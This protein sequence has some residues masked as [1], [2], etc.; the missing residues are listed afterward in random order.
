MDLNQGCPFWDPEPWAPVTMETPVP[1]KLEMS[2]FDIWNGNS[3][4]GSNIS[5]SSFLGSS[6]SVA[7]GYFDQFQDSGAPA[8]ALGYSSQVYIPQASSYSMRPGMATTGDSSVGWQQTPHTNLMAFADAAAISN[9]SPFFLPLIQSGNN[10]GVA[11]TPNTLSPDKDFFLKLDHHNYG[12]ADNSTPNTNSLM[13]KTISMGGADA[14]P[15][16]CTPVC[17][18]K[19]KFVQDYSL[20][21]FIDLLDDSSNA[22]DKWD[23]TC[24]S[25]SPVPKQVE[26]GISEFVS[27]PPSLP[28]IPNSGM[29]M[30]PELLLSLQQ[31]TEVEAAVIP[32]EVHDQRRNQMTQGKLQNSDFDLNKMPQ[33]KPKMKKHRPKVIQQ[34]KPAR[35]PKPTT[36]MP[37]TP[38]QKR[39]YVRRKN[40]QASSEILCDKQGETT[41][42]HCNADLGSSND[43]GSNSLHKRNYVVSDENTLFN[44]ISN[45]HGAT[46]PQYICG[47]S[48]VRRRL[49]F[50]SD[51]N[52]VELSKVMSAYNLESLDQATCPSGN[53]TNRNAAVNMLH[54]G[55]L[56]VMDNLPP[57]IQFS[58][59]RSIDELPNN[60]MSFTEKTV[61]TYPQAGSDGTITI[62][63][64]HN[65]C[66]T[67]SENP[68]TP[69]STR[70]ENLKKLARKKFLNNTPNFDSQQTF[71]L[72]QKKKRTDHV[73]EEYACA[74]VGEKLIEYKDASHNES[75]LS[76]VFDKQR[77][78]NE[79]KLKSCVTSSLTRMVLDASMNISV[80]D[81]RN[82]VNLKNQLDAEDILSLYQTE[83]NTVTRSD[84]NLR[85]DC[86]TPASSV[87]EHNNMMKPGKGHG[88]L[89]TFAHN[90]LSTP[91][92]IFGAKEKYS[93]N[94]EFSTCLENQVEMKRKR[95]RKN[96]NAQNG[97]HITDMYHVDLQGQKVACRELI[98]FECCQGQKTTELPMFS[99]RDFRKQGCNTVSIDSL[100]SDV[101]IPYTNLLDDVTCRLRD[102]RIYESDPTN[103]QNAIV[104]YVGDGVIVPYEGP[105][106]LTKKR[107]PRPKV[108]LDHETNRVWN[109]LMGKEVGNN[110]QGTDV[111]KEKWWEEERQVFRGRVDSFIA[112]MHLVQG[113]RRFTKWKGS[114]VDS[115]VGVFLTQN[116]S[117]HLSSS[118]FMALAAKFPLKSR[119][120]NSEFIEQDTCGKHED[121]R[122]PC[123]DGISKLHGQT[124]DRQLHVTR[125]LVAVNYTGSKENVMG[126][127][128]ESP[129]RESDSPDTQIGGCA[130]VAEPEDRW[131]MEDVG[132]SQDSVVSSQDSSENAVQ[133]ID[134]IGI[135]SLPNI[136]AEDL[137]VQNLCHGIDKSTS[138]TGLLNYVLDVSDNLRNNNP[139]ILMPVINSQDHKHAETNL[140]AALPLPHLFDDSSS[141]GLTVMEHV[142]AHTKRS[143]SHP[144]SN[145]SEIKKANTTEKLSSSHEHLVDNISGVIHS[146]NF[147]AFPG[148]QTAIGL[149]S[150]ACENSLK[151]L[152]SAEAESCLR[153][154]YYYPSSLGTELNEALLGQSI[155]QGCSLISENCSIKLQQEDRIC[156]TRS[157]KKATEFDLQK[158]HYDTQQK[159]QVLHNDKDPWE[160]S[161]SLQS[162]LKN[163]DALISN[164]LSAETPK[165]KAKVNKLKI[166]NERKVYDWES[167]RKEVCYGGIEK[168]RDLHNMD[169]VD[170]EA[171]RS[172]DVK[173]ISATI[174]ERGMNNLLA[175]RIK[176]FL[177][178]LVRDHGSIDLE[179]LRQVEPDKTKDYLLSIRGLGLK[180]VECV[181]LLTL[182]HL[183]FPV[184][185]NVGR[186]AVRLGWV[187]L[188][189]LPES[190]QLHLLELY[191]ILDTVQKYLWP[192]LCK[193]DQRTLYELHYQMITFGKVFC[194]KSKPNCNACPMRGECKHFASAFASARLAL[195]GPEE[196]SLVGMSVPIASETNHVLGVNP[197]PAYQIEGIS[198]LQ[199]IT[200]QENYGPIIEEPATPEAECGQIEEREI[201]DAF[202]DDPDEIPRIKLNIEEFTQ[203]LQSYMQANN[204][205]IQDVD[206]SKALVSINPGVAS[207]PMPKLKNVSR[208][209]TEHHVY[210]LPDSHPLLEGLDAR[211][212]DDPSSY[213]LAIWTPGETAQS[214]EPPQAS[215][216]LHET[217]A[218]CNMATCFTCSSRREA[219]AQI[220]RGTILIPCRTAM[221]GSF[222]LNGTYFQVNEVFADHETSQ[223][224]IDVPRDWIWN[225]PRRTVYF[226]TSVPSIFKGLTTEEIQLCFWRGFVCVRGFDRKTRAPRPL[227]ARLHIAASK[228]PKNDKQD[229]TKL[230]K[231]AATKTNQNGSA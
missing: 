4:G 118:A 24:M 21:Q 120:K 144:D 163:D 90:E 7:T 104:P 70:R 100:N 93:D 42:P 186:I 138:F 84:L 27:P 221:R 124:V 132:S 88:R 171:I 12:L 201:E 111:E 79:N 15:Y 211:E 130:C 222:P 58:L 91:P 206:M 89:N 217:G 82:L 33:Q 224:P 197:R 18:E 200:V 153:K 173:E 99:T 105:F 60:Q 30:P 165:N 214:T 23:S 196:K 164:R 150:D 112:R 80:A 50:E 73:L 177:N 194:T 51:R 215:C 92:E 43:I 198:D 160:I 25:Q 218:L 168:E 3:S 178:R 128:H 161:K 122:I 229:K 116:V 68:P 137:M 216:N 199:A 225:L 95:P 32:E 29:E 69:Q 231:K 202:Y 59:N 204:M 66:T 205:E 10:L 110:D 1:S 14:T 131:S 208:L 117:D 108:D 133:I 113:D 71:N 188:Q 75:D 74:N 31:S 55:S 52:A 212:T 151:P 141:S 152:C 64:V 129:D 5:H 156:E 16:P 183:A 19:N 28:V 210:E 139:S 136:R 114:V 175:D 209:R 45:P 126:A 107:R 179:W 26:F 36:P 166:D 170:W 228:A 9:N 78:E 48:S 6:S 148:T 184:D 76:Q 22:Q 8:S 174:R 213:L 35:M 101:M 149:F 192:R 115:V 134:H 62:D 127:S 154:P 169:S 226:G 98:P 172:A 181:R 207:I 94:H 61:K 39:K 85:P 145:L 230:S 135:N 56:E 97:T 219:Q 121:S 190:L 57:V 44:S 155:Y 158:Q 40:A 81:V 54:T 203:N 119:C 34:G 162:D 67:V 49:V 187:P 223:K 220:V 191:P 180:S 106:D 189:P 109:L 227:Y 2:L 87:A 102:L 13:G 46:D 182:H 185:T 20:C 41:L 77:G 157:T 195:P 65:R 83:G 142:N 96:K 123:L 11:A 38:S 53:T 47:T 159:S 17:L 193:L 167:L 37:K 125:P 176:D 63:Q 72:L 147:E 146:Q 140:S 86:V 143:M 103:I